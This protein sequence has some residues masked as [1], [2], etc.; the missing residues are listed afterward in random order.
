[1]G[2]HGALV[3]EGTLNVMAPWTSKGPDFAPQGEVGYVH[4][5]QWHRTFTGTCKIH[6][7]VSL[8]VV[9]CNTDMEK[10]TQ[11]QTPGK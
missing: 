3:G 9:N 1:M 5:P 7:R 10:D 4:L 2:T 6:F 11:H 8:S